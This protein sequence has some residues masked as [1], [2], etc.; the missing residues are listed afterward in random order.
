[1]VHY[2]AKYDINVEATILLL[3]PEVLKQFVCFLACLDPG[4][5]IIVPEPSYANYMAFA[6]VGRCGG[7]RKSRQPSKKVLPSSD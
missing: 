5:E 1:L 6:I 7:K 2:Y 3:Q 4:D